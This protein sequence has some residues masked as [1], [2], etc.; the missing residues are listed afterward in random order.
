MGSCVAAVMM[1]KLIKVET[2]LF[3]VSDLPLLELFWIICL[4]TLADVQNLTFRGD[5]YPS[6]SRTVC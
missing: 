3:S 4:D 1:V 2:I 6:L 5:S